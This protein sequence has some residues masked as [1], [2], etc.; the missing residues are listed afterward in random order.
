MLHFFSGCLVECHFQL[1]IPHI[2]VCIYNLEFHH[3]ISISLNVPGIVIFNTLRMMIRGNHQDKNDNFDVYNQ[4]FIELLTWLQ[5]KEFEL[6]SE[7]TSHMIYDIVFSGIIFFVNTISL[8]SRS[9]ELQ[10]L[11]RNDKNSS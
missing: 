9:F 7:L 8:L 10:Y 4:M 2:V 6:Y 3:Y 11:I 5:K 1:D